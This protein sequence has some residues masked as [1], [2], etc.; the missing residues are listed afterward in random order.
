MADVSVL[1]A[2]P[3]AAV[4]TQEPTTGSSAA[5]ATSAAQGVCVRESRFFSFYVLARFLFFFQF[6]NLLFLSFAVPALTSTTPM[7]PPKPRA[8]IVLTDSDSDKQ[9]VINH[10]RLRRGP[11]A[12]A[13]AAS[14]G[15][16][17]ASAV[18]RGR[19][20]AKA[21]RSADGE[22][23]AQLRML[24]VACVLAS[25]TLCRRSSRVLCRRKA[26][27]RQQQQRRRRRQQRNPK[28]VIVVI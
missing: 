26:C 18:V 15:R 7:A 3:A 16:G 14:G 1:R 19:A 2:T 22:Q 9:P 24:L 13:A 10:R 4:A 8:L 6:V 28:S 25:L 12:A 5:P 20:G 21:V 17:A 23:R 27:S 11:S